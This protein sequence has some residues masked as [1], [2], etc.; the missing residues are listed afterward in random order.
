MTV[1]YKTVF[2]GAHFIT[3]LLSLCMLA[4]FVFLL[5][6]MA[7]ALQKYIRSS[8]IQKKKALMKRSLG[9]Q[10]KDHRM[11]CNMTQE[12]VAENLGIS[13][14]AVSK[15]ESGSTD[16]STSNLIALANLFKITVEE[17]IGNID[18]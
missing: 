9:E 6:L 12:F 14:Q 8:D 11:K 13:R 16:P 15:W 2:S 17:L 7:K 18:Q 10:I 1:R 4:A 5:V 3:L